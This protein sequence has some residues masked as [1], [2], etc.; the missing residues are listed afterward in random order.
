MLVVYSVETYFAEK[1]QVKVIQYVL[2]LG[3]HIYVKV[4]TVSLNPCVQKVYERM[5]L[6]SLPDLT[7]SNFTCSTLLSSVVSTLKLSI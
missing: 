5:K 4:V 3:I 1:G 7:S 6:L 2:N